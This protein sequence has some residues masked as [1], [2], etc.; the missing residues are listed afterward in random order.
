MRPTRKSNGASNPSFLIWPCSGW[1][2]PPARFP[3]RDGVSYTSVSPS[4]PKWPQAI[5]VGCL[6]SVALSVGF[7]R[8][9]ITG[10][11]CS[12]KLGLSSLYVFIKR[13][14]VSLFLY[15]R[16]VSI[17]N[18]KLLLSEHPAIIRCLFRNAYRVRMRLQNPGLRYPDKF[19][20]LMQIA[21]VDCPADSHTRP[22]T[23]HQLIYG[24]G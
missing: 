20:L 4:P 7:L 19:R 23:S 16:F 3:G 22:Q 5:R 15:L 13:D 8:P 10:H 6:V 12:L 9:G 18:K 1:G 24:I 21:N 11:P 14:R 17:V 2:L